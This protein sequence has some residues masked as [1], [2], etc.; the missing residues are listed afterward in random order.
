MGILRSIYTQANVDTL[1]PQHIP[2][3][4]FLISIFIMHFDFKF[5]AVGQLLRAAV[6]IYDLVHNMEE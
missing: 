4:G 1:M 5:E 6:H 3:L 2:Y